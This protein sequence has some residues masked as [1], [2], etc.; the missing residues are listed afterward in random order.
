MTS[1]LRL[2]IIADVGGAETRHIGD[3]AMLE[4]NLAAFRR[5]IPEVAFTVVSRDPEWTAARY[6]VD[7]VAP[8]GF[9][10]D[11]AAGQQR[12]A[13][14]NR[15]LADVSSCGRGNTNID[16]ASDAT[17]DAVAR[18]DGLVVSGGGNL[19]STWP[20]LLYERVA[21]LHLARIFKKP[22]VV[23]GQTIGP[24]LAGD[25]RR[26][27]AEALSS[28][29]FVGVR[30]RPSAAF[31]LRLGVLPERIW[32]QSDDAL[33]LETDR[34]SA[35]LFSPTPA[36]SGTSR[37]A[38][39]IDPQVRAAGE[40][41]FGALVL[42]LREISETT[43]ATLMLIA[44]AFGSESAAVPSD[45]TEAHL[46]ADELGL[47]STVVAAGLDARQAM[48]VTG[49]AALVISSR[50]H[51]IVFGLAAGV[52]SIG[53]YG[54][55][56]CRIKLQGAL[57]HARLERWTINYDDVTRG[58]LLTKALEL[59]NTRELVRRQI[60]FCREAWREESRQR[61]AA[62]LRALD[63]R[64]TLPPAGSETPSLEDEPGLRKAISRRW[65]VVR[66]KL[67]RIGL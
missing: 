51:A 59:W 14:L 30:E 38:V 61:W 33:F 22:A 54:D 67:R 42:Q 41:V 50:Y 2:L 46:L 24:R 11:P 8:F 7:A 49:E 27:L 64:T 36:R 56:Y 60:E 23:L 55:D 25:E 47:S 9:P 10:R 62:I 4:A 48:Q 37:I 19:S 40:A 29:R 43:G 65:S 57:A 6:D 63:P 53:I 15:L 66:S 18:A 39:T 20:D 44:H 17:S 32:Y 3:E 35:T 34:E 28:A 5:L 16:F 13:M 1:S 26:L 12:A 52:P 31:A 21:L 45:L 58:E